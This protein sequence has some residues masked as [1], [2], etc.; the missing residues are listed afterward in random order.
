MFDV[1][2]CTHCIDPL[3]RCALV[4]SCIGLCM[5]VQI[6]ST[7]LFIIFWT[8]LILGGVTTPLVSLL[9]IPN[10][11]EGTLNVSEFEFTMKEIEF[12]MKIDRLDDNL[13]AHLLVNGVDNAEIEFNEQTAKG[14]EANLW[15]QKMQRVTGYKGAMGEWTFIDGELEKRG[16]GHLSSHKWK[17]RK[18]EVGREELRYSAGA[19]KAMRLQT[20]GLKSG[21]IRV[22]PS[23]HGDHKDKHAREITLVDNSNRTWHLRAASVADAKEWATVI[24]ARTG[25]VHEGSSAGPTSMEIES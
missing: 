2:S 6:A 17:T 20:I 22:G 23:D 21:T 8:N 10:E 15:Q 18:F 1:D 9:K 19:S 12:L 25:V 4:L 13:A 24:V 3:L 14:L 11:G 5:A 16:S 7:T